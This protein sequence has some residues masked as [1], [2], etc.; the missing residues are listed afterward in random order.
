MAK[1]FA[2]NSVPRIKKK[3]VKIIA[4]YFYFNWFNFSLLLV[5]S[6]NIAFKTIYGPWTSLIRLLLLLF[7]PVDIVNVC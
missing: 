4:T 3:K 1:I 2:I 7:I 5:F 6:L